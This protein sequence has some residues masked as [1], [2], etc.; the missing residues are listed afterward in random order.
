VS[1]GRGGRALRTLRW[2]VAVVVV[3]ALVAAGGIAWYFS[4]VAL[5]VDHSPYY[6]QVVQRVGGGSVQLSRDQWSGVAGRYG[7]AWA[8]GYGTVGPVTSTTA[9]SVVRPYTPV[10]G[11]PPIGTDVW[12]DPF[13]FEGDP[14]SALGLDFEQ[15]SVRS[16]VGDLPTWYVP[17]APD[18]QTWVVFV[19]GRGGTRAESLRY[20]R[21][22]HE[23]G[24]PVVVPMYRNDIDAPASPDGRYHLGETEWRDAAAATRWAL[25]RGARDVVLAGWSMGGAIALQ[26]A[27]RAAA[28]ASSVRGLVLDS[29]VL[30]WREVFASQ[31]ADRGLPRPLSAL[32]VRVL[33]QRVDLDADRYD[34]P[35][36][37]SDLRVPVLLFHGDADSF[38]P[39]GPSRALARARPDLVTFVDVPGAEHTRAW[40]VDP[41]RYERAMTGWLTEL[42]ADRTAG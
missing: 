11:T 8:G 29:P 2:L 17:G 37:A 18:A 10:R 6:P 42:L 14:A 26:V 33:E 20:L 38:V 13:A 36:R 40:N 7:L 15:V 9:S 24:L 12:V 25:T 3:L 21:T 41:A 23:L 1:R 31:G 32:A 19:H 5:A 27:D 4:G 35:A 34:W 39:A 28:V 16:D 30:D 22:W